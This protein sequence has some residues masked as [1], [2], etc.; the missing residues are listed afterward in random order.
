MRHKGQRRRLP[1]SLD[2]QVKNNEKKVI[3]GVFS[4]HF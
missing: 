1:Q 3:R 4:D 2:P